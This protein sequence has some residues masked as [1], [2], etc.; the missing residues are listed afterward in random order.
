MS[1]HFI[2][3]GVRRDCTPEEEAAIRAGWAAEDAK[4]AL[5]NADNVRVA[6]IDS[7]ISTQAIG[8]VQPRTVAELKAMSKTEFF[9]WFDANFTSQAL[10]IGLL[11]RLTL[12]V[13]RRVL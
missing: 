7:D 9:A 11:K 2:V 8:T 4:R 1:L 10:L 5:A 3:N 6:E 13:V 12:I